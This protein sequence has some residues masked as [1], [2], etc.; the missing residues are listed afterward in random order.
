MTTVKHQKHHNGIAHE[1]FRTPGPFAI[2]PLRGNLS[3]LVWVEKNVTV[4]YLLNL[5]DRD[6]KDELRKRFGGFLGDVQTITPSL[7]YKL[8]LFHAKQYYNHRI[9]LVGDAAHTTHPLAGQ[10]FNLTI[11]DLSSLVCML[12]KKSMLGLDIGSIDTLKAY[13]KLRRPY[14]DRLIA[15]TTFLNSL[16]S[17]DDPLRKFS[18]RFG[19][20]LVNRVPPAKNFFMN[21][22]AGKKRNIPNF[23]DINSY[24]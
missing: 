22:A 7:Q 12:K 16:F 17:T 14:N 3:S 6:Y 5:S 10:N 8:K 2:L 24:L 4:D 15:M 20:D 19:I 21:Y 23:S 11:Q 1:R 18:R 13:D 9:V